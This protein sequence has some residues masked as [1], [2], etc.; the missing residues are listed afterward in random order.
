MKLVVTRQRLVYAA[1]RAANKRLIL[2]ADFMLT[3]TL[4]TIPSI[5]SAQS[6]ANK[7]EQ[8]CHAPVLRQLL[9]AAYF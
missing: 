1:E 2:K 7:C 9:A 6:D 4:F 8:E 3:K 5:I